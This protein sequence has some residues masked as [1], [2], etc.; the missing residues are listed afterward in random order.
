VG[1]KLRPKEAKTWKTSH[2]TSGPELSYLYPERQK[3]SNTK[4]VSLS[5]PT[6]SKPSF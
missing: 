3:P 4:E 2:K 6:K 5:F 1:G